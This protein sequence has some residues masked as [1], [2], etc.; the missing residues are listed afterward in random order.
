MIKQ[1]L[2]R[3]IILGYTNVLNRTRRRIKGV[4]RSVLDVVELLGSNP[5][6][7][8]IIDYSRA[9][10]VSRSTA[11]GKL[12]LGVRGG[13]AY[14]DGT[15][16]KLTDKGREAFRILEEEFSSELEKIVSGILAEVRRR[17]K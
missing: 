14:Q 1:D 15:L 13:F 16:Y 11:H 9:Y 4:R 10:G 6:G 3:S 12:R 7:V 8:R 17:N 2:R 5:D